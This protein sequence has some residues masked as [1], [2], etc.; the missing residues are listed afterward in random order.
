MNN[1][2]KRIG[3]GILIVF[4]LFAFSKEL[5]AQTSY[6]GVV[7]SDIDQK[8]VSS[9]SVQVKHRSIETTTNDEGK[10]SITANIGDTLV[11]SGLSIVTKEIPLNENFQSLVLVQTTN[12][13]L[14]E[15]VVVG[16]GTQKKINL[17]G[18]VQSVSGDVLNNRP[19]T[20]LGAGLQ[21][22]IPNL[23]ITPGTGRPDDAAAFNVRGIGSISN[24][25]APLILVDNVPISA[26]EAASINPS[27]VASISVLK[28]AGAAAIYG[29][30]A[31]FGVVLIT[32]KSGTNQKLQINFQNNLAY[33]TRGQGPDIVTDPLTVMQYKHDAATPLYD[34]YP[35]AVQA[36]A[37]K[38]KD[39]PSLP[40]TI[41]DPSNPN[42]W[43][44]YGS[45]NWMDEIYRKSAPAY[46]GNLSLSQKT[47][48]L[49]YYLSLGYYQQDGLLAQNTD[50]FKRYNL[51]S[52][53]TF[54][55][56]KW[57]KVG[58]NTAYM[59]N[60]YDYST[61]MDGYLFWNVNRIPSLSVVYNPDGT[62]TSDGAA[63]VGALKQGGRSA[64]NTND[65]LTTFNTDIALLKNSLHVKGDATFRRTNRTSEGYN[66]PLQYRT[67][68]GQALQTSYPQGAASYFSQSFAQNTEFVTNHD[69]YNLYA[70]YTLNSGP[71]YLHVLAGF[72]QEYQQ[73]DSAWNRR[74]GLISA[75]LPTTQLATGTITTGQAINDYALRGLFFR[76]NYI[77]DDKYIVEFNGRR[78]GSSR[79]PSNNRWGFFPSGSASWLVTKEKFFEPVANAIDMSLFKLRGSYGVLGNQLV[80]SYYP[81]IATMKSGNITPILDGAQPVGV[82]MP[83]V[84]SSDLTW[85]KVRSVNLGTDVAFFNNHLT[86]SY[87]WY[88]RYTDGM[89]TKSRTLPGV[90]GTT[91]PVTNAANLKTKGWE[92][93][94]EWKDNFNVA[95]SPLNISARFSLADSKAYITKY[96][97][98]S[99]LLSDHYV[100]EQLGSIWGLTNDGFFQSQAEVDALD[101][102]AVGSDDQ[103]YKFYVGDLK[104]KDLNNDKKI[105][106]GSQTLAD[107]GDQKIIGNSTPRLPYSFDFGANWKGLDLRVFLQGIGKRDWYPNSSNIY[108]WGVYAQPWTNV[109]KLDLDHWT[110][111]NPNGYFPRL[112]SYIAEDKSELG[113]PQTRYLQNASYL[114]VKNITLGYSLPFS[115]IKKWNIKNVRIYVSGENMFTM[116]KLKG[117][118]DPEGLD[119]SIYPFQKTYSCGFNVNL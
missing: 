14:D 75:S 55:I 42:A 96:D 113:Y 86:A 117:G 101:Q 68:P 50:V 116:T 79:F 108:F 98:P 84:V 69:V 73:V 82:Y 105:T 102:S 12:R 29:A 17:S 60:D 8:T 30:R 19:I 64:Y 92:L 25:A 110:P 88:T 32:T 115:F 72:N 4:S 71:H 59:Y 16:Y 45:T 66:L 41:V 6:S 90:F 65:L 5:A 54:Q 89:L 99:G 1:L 11:F 58:N 13:S 109:T 87:D 76:A 38:M 35:A 26:S 28:D 2:P 103:H 97:N 67:G 21:G 33:R 51:R 118:L 81:Y 106:Y 91:E 78:D 15:V 74:L 119:G 36:Y 53:A 22:V 83:G 7:E 3:K 27:D 44:Y 20:N 39:D 93:S 49:S 52:N 85:E 107:H 61:F 43:A 31:A 23:N 104:F 48:R 77:F 63:I 62:Y 95:S 112:K 46:N 18:A 10:F 24:A 80:D 9:V 37:Q 34:L 70:D 40:N 56:T 111:D 57:W 100:G 114:R 94:I 47:D